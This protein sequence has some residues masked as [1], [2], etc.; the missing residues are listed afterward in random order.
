[1]QD[2]SNATLWAQHRRQLASTLVALAIAL[3][4]AAGLWAAPYV[5]AGEGEVLEQLPT[6]TSPLAR[7]LAEERRALAREPENLGL[8]SALAWRY[9]EAGRSEGDPRWAG[10]AEGVL[11]PWISRNEPPDEVL[12]L[13]ATL[14][15]NRHD[16]AGADRDLAQLLAR[17]PRSAQAWLTRAVIAKVRGDLA[18]A[19]RFCMPLFRLA[20][21]L[22]ATTCLADVASLG[23]RAVAAERALSRA[24]EAAPDAPAAQRQWALVTRA[25]MRE[26]LGRAR[27]AEAGY[28]AALELAPDSYTLAALADLLLDARRP[29][30]VLDLLQGET[31]SDGLLLR[32]ALAQQQLGD[33]ALSAHVRELAA[34]FD[35]GE[36]RGERLHLGEE[37]RFAL[38]FGAPRDA[39]ALARENFLVQREPRDARA[40]LEA[41]LAAGNVTAAMPALDWLAQ[42]R[43]ED[44]RLRRLAA[45][46]E[47]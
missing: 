30:E 20:D 13:R 8:A 35:A 17:D 5:P 39:L 24:L 42:T 33:P 37:A 19:E 4:P 11:A 9:V 18:A 27:E 43:I 46:L 31:R 29:R 14:R 16:F 3:S 44:V 12:L 23:G 21:A 25:E 15:Q 6:A 7:E 10:L 45:R 41:A 26:R 22:T 34:R 38:A 36:L 28:R 32:R 40:L 47:K 2:P 1:M